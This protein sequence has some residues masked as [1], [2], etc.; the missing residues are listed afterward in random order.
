MKYSV[1][2]GEQYNYW[3]VLDSNPIYRIGTNHRFIRCQCNCGKESNV[4]IDQLIKGVNK[5]CEKC[6]VFHKKK[7]NNSIGDFSKAHFNDIKSG[8]ACRKLEFNVTQEYLWNLFLMQNKK[9]ALS[10]IEITL[11][12]IL[13]NRKADRMNISASLD[14]KN[15]NLGYIKENVQWVYKWINIMK[16]ALSD[17]DF[18][19][20]C[21][22][23]ANFNKNKDNIEPSSMKGY[24][25]RK[26]VYS[27]REGATHSD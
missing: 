14:R 22:L 15:P 10:G 11:S 27:N 17:N 26:T 5:S 16:G 21:K 6:S 12:P 3:K 9:C 8:A 24:M 13:T 1:K 18:I 23:V 19:G 20:V 25:Q 4:R 2:L 7:R